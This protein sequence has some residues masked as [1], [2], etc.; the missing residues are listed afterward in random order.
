MDDKTIIDTKVNNF[1]KGIDLQREIFKTAKAQGNLQLMK[2]SIENIKSEIKTKAISLRMS[3]DIE[4]IEKRI[5]WINT[6]KSRYTRRTKNGI[7]V[8]LPKNW[9]TIS[10]KH[11]DNSYERIMKIL[12]RLDLL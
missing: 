5:N 3:E 9:K 7:K 8:R 11:L 2:V 10:N 1:R 6:L 12:T 4:Y